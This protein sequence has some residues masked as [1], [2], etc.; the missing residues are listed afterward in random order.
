MRWIVLLNAALIA[1]TAL[2]GPPRTVTLAV[3]NMTCGTCPIVVRKALERVPGVTTATVDFDQKTAT[4]T[5]DPE[6]ATPAAL[7]RATTQAGFPSKVKAAP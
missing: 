2:A 4:V 3:D 6:K 1:T 5:F 7:T